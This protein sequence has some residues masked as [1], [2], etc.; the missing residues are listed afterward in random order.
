MEETNTHVAFAG[1]LD[2]PKLLHDLACPEL[3]PLAVHQG[4]GSDLV[5]HQAFCSQ[6]NGA[7]LADQGG[8]FHVGVPHSLQGG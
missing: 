3:L 4:L 8:E 2:Q 6:A 5:L 1:W 7:M